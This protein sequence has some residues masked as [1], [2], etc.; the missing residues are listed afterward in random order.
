MAALA[1]RGLRNSL[2]ARP[3]AISFEVTRSC[4]AHCRHCHLGGPQEEE[5]A[6]PARLGEICRELSPVVAQISG[7]EPLLR[8]DLED[9]VRA[10]RVGRFPPVTVVT[11]NGALLTRQRWGSLR[12]AGLDEF[13]LSLDYPDGRHDAFR[14][15]PGLFARLDD[16]LTGLRDR[17]DKGIT[18]CCVI[19]SD[20]YRS[21]PELAELAARWGVMLNFSCY[22][23]MRTGNREYML[24]P[25]QVDELQRI[26]RRLLD[27][28]RRR[29][30][31]RTSAHG[32][33]KIIAYFRDGRMVDCRTGARFHNVNPDGTLSPCGLIIKDYQSRAELLERFS[34]GNTCDACCTSI[35]IN[36]EKPLRYLALDNIETS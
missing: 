28:R 35:R 12:A 20:N 17:P 2:A 6:S 26:V 34:R 11:T 10:F 21:L 5:R 29:G 36:S 22:T 27:E 15:I 24:A 31:I 7:G 19:Q 23:P 1:W 25:H 13:S 3:L 9:I 16:L 32:F 14:G 4:N 30:F 8:H 33:R 18:L